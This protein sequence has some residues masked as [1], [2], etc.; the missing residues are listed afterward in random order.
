MTTIRIKLPK[1]EEVEFS[2]T[3]EEEDSPVRGNVLASGNEA[4]DRAA[5]NEVF[6]RLKRGDIWAW[7]SVCITAEWKGITADAWIGGCNYKDEI[8]FKAEGGYYGDMKVDAYDRLIEK[9]QA[10]K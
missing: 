3:V 6:E 5:E 4:L 2:L 8:A 10:L 9:L 7:A 1:I